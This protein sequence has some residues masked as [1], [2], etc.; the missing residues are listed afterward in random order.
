MKKLIQCRQY[1]EVLD[2]FDR[3]SQVSTDA[4]HTLALKACAKLR[5]RERGIR[6]HRQLSSQ[7]L[8][9]PFIQTSLIHFYMQC[10]DIDHAQQIFS[11]IGRKTIFMYG[12]LFKGYVSNDMPEKVL[13]LFDEMPIEPDEVIITILF[14]ACAKLA[15]THAVKLGK[16]VL[17]RLPTAVFQH[18]KLVNSAIDMLMKFADVAH[19][20]HLFQLI[21]NKSIVTYGAMMQGN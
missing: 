1:K 3:Q 20:E 17:N 7:A 16:D 19:A 15:N 9:D 13:E 6:I 4:T 2:L 10:H 18:H 21:K 5:D 12:A 11:A 8:Q 14:N